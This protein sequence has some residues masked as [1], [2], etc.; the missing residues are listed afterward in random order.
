MA[1]IVYQPVSRIMRDF[2]IE[3]GL[4]FAYSSGTDWA[5]AT[6]AMPKLPLNCITIHD[7]A[8]Q[9]KVRVHSGN[10]QED[11]VV[12]IEVRSTNHEP[13]QYKAKLIMEAMDGLSYW[14][15]TGDSNEY[16]QTVVFATARRS[17]GVY[18]LGMDENGRFLFNL[19]FALV[20]QS[21]N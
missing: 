18:D 20:I 15:W 16:S 21:I 9:K 3:E 5:I 2:L 17:R 13:G 14:T 19:E 8:A 4:G 11:P 7:E 12:L 1:D 10:V 6:T